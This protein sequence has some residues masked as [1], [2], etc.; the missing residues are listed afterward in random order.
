MPNQD[1][2]P[3]G[4]SGPASDPKKDPLNTPPRQVRQDLRTGGPEVPPFSTLPTDQLPQEGV[5]E[6]W[7]ESWQRENFDRVRKNFFKFAYSSYQKIKK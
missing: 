1:S 4:G 6:G 3:H 7:R 5:P 2:T